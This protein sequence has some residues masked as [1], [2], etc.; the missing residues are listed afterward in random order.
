M[1]EAAGVGYGSARKGWM[2]GDVEVAGPRFWRVR[3]ADRL[4]R[5]RGRFRRDLRLAIGKPDQARH[6][7]QG[8]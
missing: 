5:A 3:A 4:E 2:I 1:D 6:P 8:S 7:D